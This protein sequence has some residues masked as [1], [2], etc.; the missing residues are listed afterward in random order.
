MV[1]QTIGWHR[2]PEGQVNPLRL[3]IAKP[4]SNLIDAKVFKDD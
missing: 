4:D 3:M 1:N 2:L